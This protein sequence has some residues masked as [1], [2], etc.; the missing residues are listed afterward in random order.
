MHGDSDGYR[1]RAGAAREH[2]GARLAGK[3]ALST[4]AARATGVHRLVTGAGARAHTEIVDV[5]DLAGVQVA[6]QQ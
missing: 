4:G 1:R 5:G 2:V 6:T 3:V